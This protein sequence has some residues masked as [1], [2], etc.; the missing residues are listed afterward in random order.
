MTQFRSLGALPVE[1][2]KITKHSHTKE[3]SCYIT[4]GLTDN[5][6]VEV[7]LSK[8]SLLKVFKKLNVLLA[9][10]LLAFLGDVPLDVQDIRDESSKPSRSELVLGTSGSDGAV[11]VVHDGNEVDWI[12]DAGRTRITYDLLDI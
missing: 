10:S 4:L 7:Q 6:A 3:V 8:E 5:E 1:G 11:N 12:G 9:P 2:F